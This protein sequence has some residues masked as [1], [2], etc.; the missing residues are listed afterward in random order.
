MRDLE[1]RA[2][3]SNDSKIRAPVKLERFARAEGQRHKGAAPHRLLLA[4]PLFAPYAVRLGE[5]QKGQISMEIMHLPESLLSGNQHS[6][7]QERL[8][9]GGRDRIDRFQRRA[10]AHQ[11]P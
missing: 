1:L 9:M 5:G 11:H 6:R 7:L 8:K 3:A 10:C 2:L 4:L